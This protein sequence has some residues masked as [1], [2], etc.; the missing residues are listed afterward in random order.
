MR[1]N[2]S[3]LKLV[4][5][6]PEREGYKDKFMET[7]TNT[8]APKQKI[9]RFVILWV[10]L[11]ILCLCVMIVSMGIVGWKVYSSVQD[12]SEKDKTLLATATAAAQWP[13]VFSDDFKNVSEHWYTGDYTQ[14]GRHEMR[15]ISNGIYN[16]TLENA[17][18]YVFWEKADIGT[19]QNFSLSVDA[20]HTSG[21]IYDAYG[22]IFCN[23]GGNYYEFSIRDSGDYSVWA[24]S[25]NQWNPIVPLTRSNAIKAGD[26]NHLAVIAEGGLFKLFI[27]DIFVK[28]FHDNTLP[29]GDV[30]IMANPQ[31]QENPRNTKPQSVSAS[32]AGTKFTAEYDNFAL[33]APEGFST[34][35]NRPAQLPP[36]EPEAGRLVFASDRAG[37]RD[38]Y[39]ISSNG[40]GLKQL[41]DDPA[42]DYAPRWSPDG[43]K[44]L[45]CSERDG[46]PEIY[47]M[48]ADGKNVTRLTSNPDKDIS[49]DWS[50]DG[51]QII[52][53]SNRAGKFHIFMMPAQGEKAG[54]SQLT[55]TES[56]EI[57]P[58]I[59]PDGTRVLYL[60]EDLFNYDLYNMGIDGKHNEVI[61][62]RVGIFSNASAAWA[63]D[64]KQVVYVFQDHSVYTDIYVAELK[65]FGADYSFWQV[66]QEG[67][68]NLFPNW[69]PK[70]EQIVFVSR[71]DD[72]SDIFIM[73]A[74]G[75]GIFR[76]THNEA[77]EESP[78]WIV[79]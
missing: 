3:V 36:I 29:N 62:Y 48:D 56:N 40:S 79:P 45:F 10:G 41:T 7:P 19:F 4:K 8:A 18:N 74:D 13:V 28:E 77:K 65:K 37:N 52:F 31:E 12:A 11:F 54:L 64:G 78:D 58:S 9:S 32:L 49:P 22:L 73:L 70:G 14:N 16:W 66:S 68:M 44:I 71:V 33:R 67:G 21:S 42:A 27:N 46:N 6:H 38:I 53:A 5:I 75:D 50:P 34:A 76:V 43:K 30:G 2:A 17:Q 63:P 20:R 24:Q 25:A 61:S 23:V 59:S 57:N 26:F 1:I 15:S 47:V 39:T 35:Q 69:S 55:D 72:Q 51:K 60:A